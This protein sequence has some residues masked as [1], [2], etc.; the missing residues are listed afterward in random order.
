[1]L[2]IGGLV[3]LFGCV[4]GSYLASGGSMEPLIEAVPF[5]MWTIGGAAIA[6]MPDGQQHARREAHA[7]LVR[8]NDERRGLPQGRT[9]SSC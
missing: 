1:M 3:M 8:Q 4:L 9:T 2:T 6:T 5:E 7:R